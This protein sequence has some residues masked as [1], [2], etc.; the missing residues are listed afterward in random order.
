MV[1]CSLPAG[2][3]ASPHATLDRT[4]RNPTRPEMSANTK[5][6]NITSQTKPAVNK[7][8]WV[9]SEAVQGRPNLARSSS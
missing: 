2:N 8:V 7:G 1:V 6:E 5:A 9:W 3:P 4:T